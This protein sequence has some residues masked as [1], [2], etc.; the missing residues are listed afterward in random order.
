MRAIAVLLTVAAVIYGQAS[1][2]VT[3]ALP[4]TWA[5]G[6]TA[7]I[8]VDNPGT[9]PVNAWILEFDYA[10]GIGSFWNAQVTSLGNGR[11]RVT[12]VSSNTNLAAGGSVSFGF[13]GSWNGVPPSDPSNATLNGVGAPVNGVPSGGGGGP[14]PGACP[15]TPAAPLVRPNVAVDPAN[16]AK[17]VV[18]YFTAWS[19]YGRNYHVPDVPADR[20]T[21]IN[22]AFANIGSNLLIEL[23]DPYADI[24]RFYPGDSWAP[25]ALRGS[26][27]RLRLLKQQYPHVRTLISV[28]GW[29]WS[30]RFSDAALTPARRAA[31][32]QSCVDFIVQYEFDGV[33]ID[34]EYPVGGGLASNTT[35]PQ[36]KQNYTLLLAELRAR[37]DAQSAL[38]GKPYLLTIAAPAGP[39]TYA[40]L[41]L[42]LI[43]PYLDWINV[44][45][46]DFHGSWSPLTNFHNALYAA[47][48]DPS[49]GVV[50][51]D[52]NANAAVQAY[53]AEGIPSDK[54][55][56]GTPFYGRGWTGVPV[57]N[58]GLWQPFTGLPQGTWEPGVYDYDDI[59]DNLIPSG[60]TRY[61]H[62]EAQVPW[63]YDPQA[64]LMV[65]YEDDQSLANKASYVNAQGLGGIM[66]WE[67]S[68][69]DDQHT[70]LG[71]LH[72]GL[73]GPRLWLQ[74][75][76]SGGGANDLWLRVTGET[77]P[78]SHVIVL[79]SATPAPG[80]IG[81][82]PLF[83]LVPDATLMT[84][85]GRPFA[86]DDP[87][88]WP[89][90]ASTYTAGAVQLPPCTGVGLAG[91]TFEVRAFA[92]DVLGG[93]LV[94][95]SGIAIL[96][97]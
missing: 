87:L 15:T 31:F 11:W 41:E 81:S 26:F 68:S 59:T 71:V 52:F 6:F 14:G 25:G 32:A 48:G 20:L 96:N 37:L 5:S 95:A 73:V 78:A 54:I 29:T 24:D 83:G 7:Q 4:S 1:P 9:S 76:T 70:L 19:V 56:L 63:V 60:A 55:V 57:S 97:W 58:D 50:A 10:H 49:P 22:Y 43:H 64:G 42:G 69:D 2:T 47:S 90:G 45:A 75:A 46:Y 82:G 74:A 86:P 93:T 85:L 61:W 8:T 12:G 79:G 53:L 77:T 80:G 39:A 94:A 27:N 36:D 18:G 65:S 92:Y 44:M 72:D 62:P 88:H 51:T 17:R 89:V 21:H 30:G 66:F 40:N 3:Y 91:Q 28:G 84:A 67:L 34:W 23:G 35:R 13:G 33:D 16:P 38:D